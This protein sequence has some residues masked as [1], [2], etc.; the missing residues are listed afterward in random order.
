MAGHNLK[1]LAITGYDAT[2]P[3]KPASG[4]GAAG[5]LREVSAFLTTVSSDDTTST[6]ALVRLPS[7]CIVKEILFDTATM[8]TSSAL[9]VGAWYSDKPL[10]FPTGNVASGTAIINNFFADNLDVSSAVAITNITNQSGQYTADKR[11]K[12]LWDA[13]ALTS[14]PGGYIDIVAIPEA[15]INTGALMGISVRYVDS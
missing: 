5:V 3:T 7:N 9:D 12:Q 1:S 2:P 13:L 4:M 10:D 6:Y 8:S 15:T 11:N 14:D